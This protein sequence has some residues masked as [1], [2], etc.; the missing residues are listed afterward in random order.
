VVDVVLRAGRDRSVR[1]RHPWLLSGAVER[2][3]GH[4]T[5]GALARVLSAEGE[6]LGFGHLSP[7]SVIRV[8]LL[9]FGKEEPGEESLEALIRA[10]CERRA[11]DPLLAGCDALRLVN[12]EG[13]GLP[14]LV[15]DRYGEVMVAKLGSAGMAA[16][17]ERI[18]AV[19]REAS[20]AGC[21]FERADPVSARQEGI[22]PREGAL[23]GEAPAGP[24]PVCE[25]GRR[26]QV[27]VR[28]GQKTGFYLDQRDARDLVES[29]AAGRRMLDLF[30]YSGGFAV[31]AARG[32]ARSVEL[33][34]SSAPALA[35]ARG[36]LAENAPAVAAAFHE[37]DVFRFLREGEE[38]YELLAL[39][40][41]PLARRRRD[42]A[43]A[44]RAYK[45]LLL[46]ALRRAEPE[47]LLLAFACSHHVGADLFRKIAFG[48]A[49]D[50]GRRLRVL[51][52][53]G[54]PSDHPVS[55]DHPEGEYLHGLLLA[56]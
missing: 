36:H 23:W 11:R 55:L 54:A 53:L 1:R 10:A 48:A 6:P 38:R 49:C 22:A 35:L 51:R 28:R 4:E 37:A 14:G 50:A 7:H 16:R 34:E 32:G 2:V 24:V 19:L 29:V 43:H 26:F 17:R 30:A 21:G 33:V 8:R 15:A 42:V 41:P 18:A 46:H 25:R 3:L 40:P 44:A 39:D 12:A 13:D 5:P 9:G 56:A 20:G 47:A 52:R 45:D 31:A 27:D